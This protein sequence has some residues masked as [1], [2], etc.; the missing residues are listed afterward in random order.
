M[1]LTQCRRDWLKRLWRTGVGA[2]ASEVHARCSLREKHG[3]E[4][5]VAEI[6]EWLRN[7]RNGSEALE[8]RG[9]PNGFNSGVEVYFL[10]QCRVPIVGLTAG[11]CTEISL[12]SDH[13]CG[14]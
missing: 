2:S 10:S 9:V 6:E 11:P 14:L 5:S 3:S 8:K 13:M 4:P 7:H 12:R 1:S